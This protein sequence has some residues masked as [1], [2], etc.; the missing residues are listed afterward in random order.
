MWL[1]R[2]FVNI[3]FF[4]P[5]INALAIDSALQIL[6]ITQPLSLLNITAQPAP[7]A[8][9]PDHNLTIPYNPFRTICDAKTYGIPNIPSC[10]NVYEQ[11]TDDDTKAQF[12]DRTKG[13]WRYPLPYRFTSGEMS[14]GLEVLRRLGRCIMTFFADQLQ[15]T[16]DA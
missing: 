11:M 12:G 10:L 8:S 13:L 15:M 3:C 14:Q 2:D 7:S 6:N 4:L 1:F 16:V 5:L 9:D